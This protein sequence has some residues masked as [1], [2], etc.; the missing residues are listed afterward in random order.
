MTPHFSLEEQLRERYQTG[1]ISLEDYY[2]MMDNP[3]RAMDYLQEEVY[4]EF[5]R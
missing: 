3:E 2:R 5:T 1:E 4:D